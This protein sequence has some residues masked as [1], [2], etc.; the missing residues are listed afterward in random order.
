VPGLRWQHLF[1]SFTCWW[2][3]S[4]NTNDVGCV[5][6]DLLAAFLAVHYFLH[7]HCSRK[8]DWCRFSDIYTLVPNVHA[9]NIVSNVSVNLSKGIVHPV[10]E[11]TTHSNLAHA[12][13]VNSNIHNARYN[14]TLP[15]QSSGNMMGQAKNLLIGPIAAALI[16]QIR[17]SRILLWFYPSHDEDDSHAPTNYRF[18]LVKEKMARHELVFLSGAGCVSPLALDF[19]ILMKNLATA[20]HN[21]RRMSNAVNLMVSHWSNLSLS[22]PSSLSSFSLSFHSSLPLSL[23]LPLLSLPLFSLSLPLLSSSSPSLSPSLSYRG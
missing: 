11:A 9:S 23:F 16:A 20:V 13:T 5:W 1:P 18:S 7:K 22:L 12:V 21:I 17:H 4:L 3:K 19:V 6:K 2:W 14:F 10:V 8:G 15:T